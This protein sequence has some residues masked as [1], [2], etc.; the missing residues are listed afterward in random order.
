MHRIRLAGRPSDSRRPEHWPSARPSGIS[1]KPINPRR[2]V[3]ADAQR[4]EFRSAEK[5][6]SGYALDHAGPECIEDVIDDDEP[7]WMRELRGDAVIIDDVLR[8]V[9]TVDAEYLELGKPFDDREHI[10]R[11]YCQ[12]V[13][14]H[15]ANQIG[16]RTIARD[17]L[18]EH[19]LQPRKSAAGTI[20]IQGL[21]IEYVDCQ[22]AIFVDRIG[23]RDEE[24]PLQNTN[25]ARPSPEAAGSR[26]ADQV[27]GYFDGRSVT[28]SLHQVEA[29]IQIL[30]Q[31]FWNYRR[32]WARE[33]TLRSRG[34]MPTYGFD[35]FAEPYQQRL[36]FIA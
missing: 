33:I 34:A 2:G 20:H 36:D 26:V 5:E 32:S 1:E 35:P 12:T 15:L 8:R 10:L 31:R 4:H 29:V 21:V 19:F 16:T 17:V 14:C 23:Q 25:L 13:P 18:P 9:P 11:T 6:E 24:F 7:P 3:Q 28:P 30:L 27:R 22:R